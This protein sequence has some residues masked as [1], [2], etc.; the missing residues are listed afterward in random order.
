MKIFISIF[1]I[2]ISVSLFSQY[3][4]VIELPEKEYRQLIQIE[5]EVTVLIY[6]KKK[7]KDEFKGK[8]KITVNKKIKK[9]K[10]SYLLS[11]K[12]RK[13]NKGNKFYALKND[14]TYEN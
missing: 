11:M 14:V 3:R 6:E 7:V 12:G 4:G 1:L 5:D 9:I 10:Q 2:L 13:P 8:S